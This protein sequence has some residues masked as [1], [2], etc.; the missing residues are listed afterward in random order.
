MSQFHS[1]ETPD[2]AEKAASEIRRIRRMLKQ[3][4]R[5]AEH[6]SLTGA[7]SAGATDA[8]TQY[9]LILARLAELGAELG[10]LFPPLPQDA[11]FDRLGVASKLLEG[12]LEEEAPTPPVSAQAGLGHNI[13]IGGN[14][15]GLEDLQDIGRMVRE[16]LPDFL[17]KR[18][19]SESQ[20]GTAPPA[21]RPED[22]TS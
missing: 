21:P 4:Y 20:P 5:L 2:R 22:E 6:A 17:R 13:V 18:I 14:I 1:D 9:N 15:T 7:F 8:V 12:Y 11:S 10:I 19:G 3:M 16:N